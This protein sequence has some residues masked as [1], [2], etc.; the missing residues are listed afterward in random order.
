MAS[1]QLK[2]R[3]E[4]AGNSTLFRATGEASGVTILVDAPRGEGAV[5]RGPKPMELLSMSLA[6]CVATNLVEILNK[7]RIPYESVR[8]EIEAERDEEPPRRFT[9]LQMRCVVKSDALEP[10]V[11]EQALALAEK[12]CPASATLTHGLTLT[13]QAEVEREGGETGEV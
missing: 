9:A 7:K 2:V 12:H 3:V 13:A 6:T 4:S 8:L 1:G 11:L 5:P 10:R